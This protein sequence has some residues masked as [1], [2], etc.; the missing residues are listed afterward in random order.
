MSHEIRTPINGVIGISNL[1]LE[2]KLTDVQ[3]EYVD[4]L[5]FSAQHLSSIVSDI[6]DFSKIE[7]G[8]L[9][10]EKVPF[11][12][13]EVASNVFKLFENKANEKQLRFNF[14]PDPSIHDQLLGDYVRLSQILSNL[15]SN[16][17]KFTETGSIELAYSLKE[18]KGDRFLIEFSV[19]DTGIG[20]APEQ[21]ERIF[22]NFSQAD[23]STTRKYGGTGL[24]LTICKKLVELQEGNIKVDSQL[25]QGSV[26]TVEIWYEKQLEKLKAT[27]PKSTPVFDLGGMKI[28]V[29]EDNNVNI[30][31]LT[32]LLKR[33]GAQYLV[34][35][36]GEEAI[37][38]TQ[39]EDFD[40]IIMD[41]QMPNVDGR[42]AANTIRMLPDEHKRS[43]PIIAF[44]AE[45][46]VESKQELLLSGF[47]DCLTK[48]FQP[49]ILYNTLK[50]YHAADLSVES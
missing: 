19:R 16:A 39:K 3:R 8:N 21:T 18:T 27:I 24:G 44:T 30:L 9:I 11:F 14:F 7:S 29:A 23:V 45:A 10:L 22:D 49:E 31:V 20:I 40:V 2:E 46:S 35:N 1:L 42:E 41:I 25:G 32:P 17:I 13:R 28:L 12:L 6:L 50:K 43:I 48:P 33:W 37:A 36:D 47:N 4:T 5:R 26:F 34:A 38:L 15:L